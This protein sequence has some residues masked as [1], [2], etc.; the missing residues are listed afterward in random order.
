MKKLV[1]VPSD[2]PIWN[3][4]GDPRRAFGWLLRHTVWFSLD[5]YVM[6]PHLGRYLFDFDWDLAIILDACRYD[7]AAAASPAWLPEPDKCYSVGFDSRS[8]LQ[9]TFRKADSAKL[10]E[11]AYISANH[12]ASKINSKELQLCD[13]VWQ[14]AWDEEVGAVPPR[15]VTDRAIRHARNDEADRYLVHY[16]QPHL[17]P[18]AEGTDASNISGVNPHEGY[19]KWVDDRHPWMESTAGERD[20]EPIVR[21][22]KRNI[23]PVLAE[24]Q[25]LLNNVD[26]ENVIITADH[27]NYLGERGRYGHYFSFDIHPPVRHVPWWE[28]TAADQKTHVPERYDTERRPDMTREEQL[29]ALGYR[30][31]S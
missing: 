29:T 9:R 21:A 24:L 18:L 17:P 22:Y 8:W 12:F 30:A 11:T 19:Y 20:P 27:G 15:P 2:N 28:T 3:G 4:I 14:Y 23:Q 13:Q 7:L 31:D 26:A 16:M 10:G 1:E 25:L 5:R 6:T